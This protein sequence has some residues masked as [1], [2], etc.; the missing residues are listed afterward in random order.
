MYT[1]EN[2][3][4][5]TRE[6]YEVQLLL[7]NKVALAYAWIEAYAIQLDAQVQ[8]SS[9]HYNGISVEEVISTGESHTEDDYN[10][11]GGDYI[12]R[13]GVFK[14]EQADP[15]FWDHLETLLDTKVPANNRYGFFS[16]SC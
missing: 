11:Y 3:P 7:G 9:D 8:K 15:L 1:N 13:G 2:T 16:C 12:M 5:T 10:S 14:G 4:W 6:E